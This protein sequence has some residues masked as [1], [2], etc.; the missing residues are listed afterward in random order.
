MNGEQRATSGGQTFG[1]ARRGFWRFDS[2]HCS[3]FQHECHMPQFVVPITV[4][5]GSYNCV[6]CNQ[7]QFIKFLAKINT[8]CKWRQLR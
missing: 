6:S 4:D 8:F 1:S 7:S 2:M 5:M 3:G